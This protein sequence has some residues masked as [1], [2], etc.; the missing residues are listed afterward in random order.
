MRAVWV[1][2][3]FLALALGVIGVFLPL[4]PTVPFLLLACVA[5]GK[6]SAR[7]H[8]WLLAHPRLGP[9]IHDWNERGAISQKA[10]LLASLS[11]IAAFS[12][13]WLMGFGARVLIIQAITLACVSLFIWTRPDR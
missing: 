5:F 13:S 9:P 11:I 8:R 4:L 12:I 3:G 7:L 6:S 1:T 10:K 2:I